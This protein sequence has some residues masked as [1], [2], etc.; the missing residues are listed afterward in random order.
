MIYIFKINFID[1]Y[2]IRLY[3]TRDFLLDHIL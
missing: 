2:D 3:E 1:L